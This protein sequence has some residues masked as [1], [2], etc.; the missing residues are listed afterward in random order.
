MAK[1]KRKAPRK[2]AKPDRTRPGNK[3]SGGKPTP[4]TRRTR[5]GVEEWKCTVCG[6]WKTKEDCYPI[7][8]QSPLGHCQPCLKCKAFR[9]KKV[10]HGG[11][12]ASPY[13]EFDPDSPILHAAMLSLLIRKGSATAGRPRSPSA[14]AESLGITTAQVDALVAAA[15]ARG[16]NLRTLDD[17]RI[18][19]GKHLLPAIPFKRIKPPALGPGKEHVFGILGDSHLCNKHERL[20]VLEA[21]Y[22]EYAALGIT[23]VYHAGNIVDG[24][25][26]NINGNEVRLHRAEDQASYTIDHY[27]QRPGIT[28]HYL[29]TYCHEGWWRTINFG[30]YLHLEAQERGRSDLRWLGLMEADVPLSKTANMRI[31][32]PRD[33]ASY[34]TSYAIQKHV[35]AFSEGQKPRILVVG[36]YHKLGFV[37]PRGVYA[38]QVGCCCDQ[39]GWM[40]GKRLRAEVGYCILRVKM[41]PDGSVAGVT[42]TARAWYNREFHAAM[43]WDEVQGGEG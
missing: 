38:A 5:A 30:R 42:Y 20:D 21:A 7:D 25:L 36:H 10:R 31:M 34:A 32:H 33:G 28:T 29:G 12:A 39:T 26:E 8:S 22:D 24:F 41:A 23:E 4:G 14:L 16:Y 37:I 2:A 27:P 15:T 1:R 11:T 43:S 6:E 9:A 18:Q 13:P 35:E 40:R 17:G 3:K 19:L